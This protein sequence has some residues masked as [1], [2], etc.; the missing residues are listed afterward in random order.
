MDLILFIPYV[1]A[2]QDRV[3]LYRFPATNAKRGSPNSSACKGQKKCTAFPKICLTLRCPIS[4]K[5][6]YV[7]YLCD[8]VPCQFL[9]P[10]QQW[11]NLGHPGPSPA[12]TSPTTQDEGEERQTADGAHE[13]DHDL[14]AGGLDQLSADGDADEG[15]EGADEVAGAVEATEL[16][17]LAQLADAGRDQ[18]HPGAG[19]KAE[20]GDE[21]VQGGE[22]GMAEWQ[23][24]DEHQDPGEDDHEEEGVEAADEVGDVARDNAAE[25]RARVQHSDDVEARVGRIVVAVVGVGGQDAQRAEQHDLEAEDADGE[26]RELQVSEKAQRDDAACLGLL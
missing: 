8:Q 7:Q 15:G 26:E 23:P 10:M 4:L 5:Y 24:Q 9:L 13:A 3:L 2:Q 22:A 21:G 20:E 17:G 1:I 19:A 14:G 18:G 25:A 12:Q 16:L 6:R 11:S